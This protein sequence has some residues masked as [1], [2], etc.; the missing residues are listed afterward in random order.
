MVNAGWRT[1]VVIGKEKLYLRNGCLITEKDEE[2]RQFPIEQLKQVL[3]MSD[4]CSVT[5]AL[6][7]ELA[8][9]NVSLVIC[10]EKY[11]PCCELNGILT[12][13]NAAGCLMDQMAWNE[14]T[15]NAVWRC[16]VQNKLKN[17]AFL[18]AK[19]SKE[20]A[21]RI[22]L[23][24]SN[25]KDGDASNREGLAARVY[26]STLFGEGFTRASENAVNAALNYGYSIILSAFT[27][28]IALHGYN[29]AIG[30]HHM[31]RENKT[32]LACDIMEPFR[33]FVDRLVFYRKPVDLDWTM[34]RQLIEITEAPCVYDR[35]ITTIAHAIELYT[36]DVLKA[37]NNRTDLVQ[38]VSLEEPQ[39]DTNAD[40]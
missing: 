20:A 2:A 22:D 37:M 16:I 32:K 34:K 7:R 36:A 11:M 38:E 9:N 5:T 28:A 25:I 19:V 21:D 12:H 18:A 29:P 27:R 6:M 3:V 39:R 23:Y 30:I 1:I 26:F 8:Q 14:D 13:S 4:T 10:D 31:S 33:A 35:K 24:A 15:K 40:V 17:Q